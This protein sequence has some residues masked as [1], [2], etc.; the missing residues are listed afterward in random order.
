MKLRLSLILLLFVA[1]VGVLVWLYDGKAFIP[2]RREKSSWSEIIA[3]LEACGHRKHL[4]ALQYDRF[5]QI[6]AAE[7][8]SDAE[9]L[10]RAMAFSEH[11]QEQN[12]ILAI[13]RLG[14]TYA[15]PRPGA[16]FG[17]P[18]DGN[19]ERSIAEERRSYNER[20]DAEIRRAM[21]RGNRYAARLLVWA[22]AAD[23]RKIFLMECRNGVGARAFAVCPLCG[24]LYAAEFTD[25][26][27]PFCLTD[28]AE[29]VR[30]E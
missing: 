10:F 4:K 5:A 25:R 30:F 27:C 6:A 9:H 1:S 14:G 24:N 13:R 8:R 7:K 22:A 11:L 17:G 3:D 12:C 19:L 28:G 26:F 20:R 23:L 21:S 29:F 18:T 2:P 15:A 16:I